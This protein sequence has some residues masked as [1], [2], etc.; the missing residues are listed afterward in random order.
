LLII[1]QTRIETHELITDHH[2]VSF[3]KI[4]EKIKSNNLTPQYPVNLTNME[5][6]EEK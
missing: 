5:I 6:P 3:Y 4:I 1:L 2:L